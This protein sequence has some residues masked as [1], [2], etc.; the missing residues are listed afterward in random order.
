[1][2]QHRHRPG[3]NRVAHHQP[4][5]LA[6]P[7]RALPA[8]VPDLHRHLCS[9]PR[10][11]HRQANAAHLRPRTRGPLR[12]SRGIRRNTSRDSTSTC[13]GPKQELARSPSSGSGQ[14]FLTAGVWVLP[15]VGNKVAVCRCA[16][17]DLA[18]GSWAAA[19]SAGSRW[20]RSSRRGRV[21]ID[22]EVRWCALLGGPSRSWAGT[23]R[24]RS[25]LHAGK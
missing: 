13:P 24:Y 20:R 10:P 2:Y 21:G 15:P 8:A 5:R 12:H 11:G 7:A 1:M 18:P 3:R 25:G 6:S 17:A 4:A 22:E 23:R 9:V 14:R 16:V 19:T